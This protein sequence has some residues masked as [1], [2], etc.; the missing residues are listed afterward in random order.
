MDL[1]IKLYWN[2]SIIWHSMSE[3]HYNRM[4]W[5]SAWITNCWRSYRLYC[6]MLDWI[7]SLL[8][9][10]HLINKLPAIAN[11]G[12]SQG[13]IW[14]VCYEY[15]RLHIFYCPAYYDVR[16][17]KLKHRTKKN[18]FLSFSISVKRFR[19]GCLRLR[20]ISITEM[21]PLTSPPCWK[22]SMRY[23]N[24]YFWLSCLLPC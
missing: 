20:R 16:K 22:T 13:M 4:G 12:N 18:I 9:V 5:Q 10:S 14:S 23:L 7:R 11:E 6:S 24:V 3:K 19:L 15:D 1:F 2:E 8:Y 21:W 17:S